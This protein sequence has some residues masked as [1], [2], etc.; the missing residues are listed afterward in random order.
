MDW[1][2]ALALTSVAMLP[3]AHGGPWGDG[4]IRRETQ[5]FQVV[6]GLLE[7]PAGE[8]A[9]LWLQVEKTH[10]NTEWVARQLAVA[11]GLPLAEIGYAGL[12]DRHAQVRQWFSLPWSA[13]R[14][15]AL[16]GLTGEGFEVI[17]AVRHTVK[18]RRGM[19]AGNQFEIRVRDA[20]AVPPD[21][22]VAIREQ[23]IPNY[24]GE[25]RFGHASGNLAGGIRLLN[26]EEPPARHL[27]SLYLSAL[28]A[29]IFNELLAER[30]STGT[31]NRALPG[32]VLED[33]SG[34]AFRVQ[35]LTAPLEARL[36]RGECQ[37]TGPLW[38]RPQGLAAYGEAGAVEA[39]VAARFAPWIT[40][41]AARNLGMIRRPL[42]VRPQAMTW[43]ARPGPQ[44]LDWRL[45]FGL[46]AGAYATA[47]LR[48]CWVARDSL[49]QNH[50]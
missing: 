40:G 1:L 16:H 29:Q 24:F 45:I 31:W 5:D 30:V 22:L 17:L 50:S 3:R 15:T 25:Q 11:A 20:A 23:G 9:Q 39:A 48:E 4:W 33:A 35:T 36:A 34:R 37:I 6:E 49:P 21:A 13:T 27:R 43:N 7:P 19:L 32:D 38:G 28:R 47:L 2:D 12:K 26:G 46:P 14:A 8:G 18:L 41:L 44:G 10:A 42:C